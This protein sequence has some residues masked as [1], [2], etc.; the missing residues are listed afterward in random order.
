MGKLKISILILSGFAI[1]MLSGCSKNNTATGPHDQQTAKQRVDQANQIFIPKLAEMVI[2]NGQD[3][4]SFNMSAATSLYQEALNADPDNL[5]AN[6]GMAATEFFTIFS[7]PSIRTVIGGNPALSPAPSSAF[8][9]KGAITGL[10]SSILSRSKS[11]IALLRDPLFPLRIYK[12]LSAGDTTVALSD[13]QGIIETVVLPALSDA[14]THLNVVVQHSDYI[15]YIPPQQL[16]ENSGDSIRIGLTEI[17]A[18]LATC[19]IVDATGSLLVSY[20]V[21]YDATD[22]SAVDQAWQTNSAFLA[23]RTNGAQ[24]MKDV[25]TNIIGAANSIQNGI[26]FLIQ[27]PSNGIIIYRTEDGPELTDIKNAMDSVKQFLSGPVTVSG[28]FN[29][30][31][32]QTTLTINLGKLFDNAIPNFKQKLPSY[33]VGVQ[34]D[35][36]AYDAILTWQAASF[37]TWTFPDPTFNGIFPGITTD[38]QFKQAF[39]ITAASWM[40]YV[41]ISAN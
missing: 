28:D 36:D 10:S 19:Q 11:M 8:S 40:P 34:K 29:N 30:T 22:S 1:M 12:S 16:G 13:Y 27:H 35:G 23:L 6:F 15:F 14:I 37:S 20:N 26:T 41:I 7:N 4:A 3:T 17:Y 39:G 31:G 33:T 5:D 38:A 25:K 2:S 9:K 18:L 32:V 24:R 21:D